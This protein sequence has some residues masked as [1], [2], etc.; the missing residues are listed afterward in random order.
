[1]KINN[2]RYIGCKNKLIDFISQ[3]IAEFG[4]ESNFSFADI[5]GGTG[6]VANYYAFKNCEIILNDNLYSNF[7]AYQAFFGNEEVSNLKIE[8]TLM[9]L[10]NLNSSNLEDNYFSSIYSHKY[11]HLN[12]AK[13][14]GYIRDWIEDHKTDFNFREYCYLITSLIYACDKIANTVGHFESFLRKEPIEKGVELKKLDITNFKIKHSLFNMDA[15][16]VISKFETDVLYLDPPYNARQYVNFYHVLENLARW[17]KPTIFQGESM[18][19]ERNDLKSDFCRKKAPLLFEKIINEAKAKL[20]VVSYN[21]T[22]KAGSISS[23][24]TITEEELINILSKKGKVTVKEKAYKAFSA[25]KTK[26]NNHKEYLYICEV[27]A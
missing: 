26:L 7:I 4:Y 10:N 9:F 1:M 19:F 5:F 15:N 24:N 14:I 18:K 27:N 21:N 20:I 23:V 3:T 13:K 16:D 6:V 8:E 22:Y 17:N 25:G 2:R 12:D 11:F